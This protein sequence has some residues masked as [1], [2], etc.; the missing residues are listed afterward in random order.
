M[1]YIL[2]SEKMYTIHFK[3]QITILKYKKKL[4]KIS[5]RRLVEHLKVENFHSQ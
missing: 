4:I 2:H 5:E 1:I 3:M